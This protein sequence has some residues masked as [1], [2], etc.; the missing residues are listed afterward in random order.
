MSHELLLKLGTSSDIPTVTQLLVVFISSWSC[1]NLTSSICGLS[2]DKLTERSS[3]CL[4]CGLSPNT[5]L[6]RNTRLGWAML[7]SGRN[8]S[9]KILSLVSKLYCSWLPATARGKGLLRAA[10][11]VVTA[12]PS[13]V[14]STPRLLVSQ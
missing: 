9:L 5:R 8:S 6:G 2:W 7:V 1:F 14:H 10:A 3:E 13:P 4:K 12:A 11:A